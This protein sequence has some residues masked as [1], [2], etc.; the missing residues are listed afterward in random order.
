MCLLPCSVALFG[1]LDLLRELDHAMERLV[2]RFVN[3]EKVELACF[4]GLCGERNGLG[5]GEADR[6]S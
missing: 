2:L 3:P 4:R 6:L 5:C 1:L